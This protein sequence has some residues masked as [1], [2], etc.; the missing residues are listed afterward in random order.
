TNGFMFRLP[1]IDLKR[2]VTL[3]TGKFNDKESGKEKLYLVL[4]QGGKKIEPFFS[5]ATPRG[6]PQP[7]ETVVNN[8]PTW[9]YTDQMVFIENMLNESIIPKLAVPAQ[10]ISAHTT[11]ENPGLEGMPEDD[12]PF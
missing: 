3:R 9:D 6:L 7:K 2:P 8:K 11:G 4:E 10:N 5:K 12:L 1:N